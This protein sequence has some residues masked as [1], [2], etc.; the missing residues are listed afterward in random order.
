MTRLSIV[1]V[2]LGNVEDVSPRARECL[3]AANLLICESRKEASRL[4]RAL[5]LVFPDYR[6]LSEHTT[7]EERSALV[8]EILKHDRVALVS[9]AGMPVLAD[10]GAEIIHQARERGIAIEAI[11]GPN[12]ALLALVLAGQGGTGFRF[13]GFPPRKTQERPVFFETL[14][15]SDVPV[16]LYET[17]YRLKKLLGELARLRAPGRW[18][19]FVGVGLT[20]EK[21]FTL[22]TELSSLRSRSEQVPVGPPVVVLYRDR[23]FSGES[24]H[25]GRN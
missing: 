24:T 13:A 7:A 21:E 25:S 14:V 23:F 15:R 10:P 18:R 8:G 9:D 11:A 5:G 4:Y 3:A 20:T 12:A 1:G 22:D 19:V 2:H 6:E 17:P 16:V